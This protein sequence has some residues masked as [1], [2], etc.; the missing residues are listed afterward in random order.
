MGPSLPSS[1]PCSEEHTRPRGRTLASCISASSATDPSLCWELREGWLWDGGNHSV[2]EPRQTPQA[3]ASRHSL[4]ICILRRSIH[5]KDSTAVQTPGLTAKHKLSTLRGWRRGLMPLSPL[6]RGG[7]LAVKRSS[8]D[9]Q[10]NPGPK[11]L[12]FPKA[13]TFQCLSA[14]EWVFGRLLF[15]WWHQSLLLKSW[16]LW[17]NGY[18]ASQAN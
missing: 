18:P 3:I 2:V 13:A 7:P 4:Y 15:A 1:G 10:P 17:E 5:G 9:A 11:P 14:G 6:E 8:M 12:G 16:R